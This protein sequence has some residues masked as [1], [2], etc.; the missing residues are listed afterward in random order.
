MTPK[1][2]MEIQNKIRNSII[3]ADVETPPGLVA[4][5]DVSYSRKSDRFYGAA[6]LYELPALR[7]IKICLAS[8]RISFPYIP[9]LLSFREGP[10]L[11][12]AFQKLDI[13]PDVV[14]FD[15]QGV[16]HPRGVGLASHMGWIFDIPTIG[17][18]KTKLVGNYSG[19][20]PNRGDE[21]PLTYNGQRVGSV[22]RTRE[23]VKPIFVSVGYK[24][25]LRS[26]VEIILRLITRY[27]LPE[28]IRRA[29]IEVN[30]FREED[31]SRKQKGL[32]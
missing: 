29:H 14:L 3:F 22:L 15:G 5:A 19:L 1:E 10:I 11:I 7:L 8:G 31:E 25:S 27:R 30:K 12:E 2:A 17:C 9:G 32:F 18:A 13:R 6:V 24:T 20:G 21:A 28:P 4:A 16:A 23:G 26:C